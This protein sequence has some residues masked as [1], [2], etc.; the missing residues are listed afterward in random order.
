MVSRA[1]VNAKRDHNVK[2]SD[3]RKRFANPL[4]DP[5]FA[6]EWDACA[7]KGEKPTFP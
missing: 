7:L 5:K 4:E 3:F 1:N 2:M 6:A